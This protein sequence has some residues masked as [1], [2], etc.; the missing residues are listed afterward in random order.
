MEINTNIINQKLKEN[1]YIS[2][3][4]INHALMASYYGNYPILIEGDP[5]VGKTALAKS[6]ASAFDMPFIRVQFYEGITADK[7][8]YDYNYQKQLLTIEALKGILE[9]KMNDKTLEE[10][11]HETSKIN[12]YGEDF[13]IERPLLKSLKS[14]K[15]CV[16]LLDEIDKVSE[17]LEYVLL[18]FLDEFAITIPELGTIKANDD[19]KPIVFLTSNSYRELS[20]ALKRRCNY[21][22]LNQKTKNELSEILSIKTKTDIILQQA[23]LESIDKIR[24]LKLTQDPSVSEIIS[25]ANYL[26]Y[27]LD[28]DLIDEDNI[29][30]TL[31]ML[32]KNK[33][34][35]IKISKKEIL[36]NIDTSPLII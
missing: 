11:I 20:D 29:K 31:F 32:S 4:I 28:E 12:F 3:D 8:L 33:N 36:N 9:N 2:N 23:I 35:Q 18:E 19:T 13:L 27:S 10:A 34:D 21:L 26:K 16:L 7:I 15:R 5:G 6:F 22:Y 24:S 1:G 17:E 14:N 25:W 30:D